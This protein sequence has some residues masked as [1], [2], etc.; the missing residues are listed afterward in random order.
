MFRVGDKVRVVGNAYGDK[1]KGTTH[2]FEIGTLGIVESVREKSCL[3]K[4]IN[5]NYNQ[6]VS[7]EHLVNIN[8]KLYLN[9]SQ[10]CVNNTPQ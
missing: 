2:G 5:K 10:K 1:L 3:V 4:C 8:F 7:K 6:F 9:E